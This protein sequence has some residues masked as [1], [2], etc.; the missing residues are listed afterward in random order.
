MIDPTVIMNLAREETAGESTF[1]WG[2]GVP[3]RKKKCISEKRLLFYIL[4]ITY[5]YVP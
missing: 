5:I 4:H 2:W 3:V 1:P